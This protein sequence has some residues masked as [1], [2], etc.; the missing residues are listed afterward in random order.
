VAAGLAQ[1]ALA[2]GQRVRLRVISNSMWPL[3][4]PGDEVEVAPASLADLRPG[5]L[6]VRAAADGSFVTHRLRALRGETIITGGDSLPGADLP[7]P[8]GQLA[9]RVSAAWRAG[10]PIRLEARWARPVGRLLAGW[11]RLRGL[12]GRLRRWM[13]LK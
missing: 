2:E 8:I 10:R 9:G 4:R 7:W 3:L 13:R 12:A 6:V 1:T 5:A 11:L